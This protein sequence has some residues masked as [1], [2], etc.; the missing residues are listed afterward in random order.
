MDRVLED[1]LED[2]GE[3]AVAGGRF[4][5]FEVRDDPPALWLPVDDRTRF[6]VELDPA[7]C[8][9]RV[10]LVTDDR[11]VDEA[12]GEAVLASR[13]TL[14][15]FLQRGLDAVAADGR[16]AVERRV[17]GGFAYLS[18]VVPDGPND[19]ARQRTRDRVADLLLAYHAAFALHVAGAGG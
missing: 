12:I 16:Y 10:G 11:G 5:R 4:A 14:D 7:A 17:Q 18:R 1:F 19:L 8:A 9:A 13:D 3:R 15:E 2:V 6:V